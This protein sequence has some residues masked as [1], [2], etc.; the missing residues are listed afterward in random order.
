MRTEFLRKLTR[1]GTIVAFKKLAIGLL[2]EADMESKIRFKYL[3]MFL[4][5]LIMFAG[6]AKDSGG[7]KKSDTTNYYWNNGLCYNE[8]GNIVEN[9]KCTSTGYYWSNGICYNSSGTAVANTYCNNN[10]GY[11]W[12]NGLCYSTSTGQVVAN[13]YCTTGNTNATSCVGIYYYVYGYS[14]VPVS[15]NGMNCRGSTLLTQN[16]VPVY[17]Q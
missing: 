17:C 14:Y 11:T 13:T 2:F 8:A 9:S 4:S 15:C 12:S 1:S 7:S 5:A 3:F 16:G 10:N 6:C